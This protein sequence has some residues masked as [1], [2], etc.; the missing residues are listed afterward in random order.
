MPT[1][2]NQPCQLDRAPRP[3]TR[4]DVHAHFLPD[5]YRHAL[6]E[7]G[8]GQPD[9]IHALP[10]WDEESAL[11]TM[12]MLGV[13]TALLSISSPGVH[14]G[15]DIRAADLACR[16]NDE[17]ARLRHAHP[18][19]FGHFA[20]L[21]LPDI[22]ASVKEAIRALDELGADG[23]VL[24]TNS[25]GVYLG[26]PP[27]EP[28]YAELDRR[29]AVI[30]IHP[31]SPACA[32]C[33]RLSAAS[34]QPMVEFMFETTRSVSDMVLSGVLDRHSNLKVIVPHAG[35]ALPV[36]SERIELLLPMLAKEG[37]PKPP[38]IV[39][40]LGQLHFDLAGAPV[41]HLLAALLSVADP[42]RLHY[43]SDYPFTPAP[44]CDTLARKLEKTP[45]L[46]EALRERI[47]RAN[48]EALFPRL[49]ALMDADSTC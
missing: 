36:L 45:V 17:G 33:T 15:D 1:I 18:A 13:R 29:A 32:C 21:P 41:P 19:R 14:F 27:L 6:I 26:D 20:S 42:E 46:S 48:A 37:T 16:C 4:I 23:I 2:A 10:E 35:A 8:E 9:G 40:A 39:A 24:E 22:E 28:L 47:W 11:R 31:T 44:I 34:P 3:I 25:G 5:F 43:G 12:D 7:A 49:V 38:S 30:F